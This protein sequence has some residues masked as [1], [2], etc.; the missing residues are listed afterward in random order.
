VTTPGMQQ[1]AV[2]AKSTLGTILNI[3][4]REVR[5]EIDRIAEAQIPITFNLVGSL[6]Q[7]YWMGEPSCPVTFTTIRGAQADVARVT[8]AVCDI[9]VSSLASNVIK[10]TTEQVSAQVRLLDV[11]GDEISSAL[12]ETH[13]AFV[14]ASVDVSPRRT[15]NVSLADAITGNAANGYE[16]KSTPQVIPSTV[17]VLGDYS[18][19][20]SLPSLSV[21]KINVNGAK[22]PIDTKVKILLPQDVRLLGSDEVEVRIDIG[23]KLG[24]KVLAKRPITV[25]GAAAGSKVTLTTNTVDVRVKAPLSQL[26]WIK[27]ATIQPYIDVTGLSKGKQMVPVLFKLPSGLSQDNVT[28]NL[29]EVEVNIE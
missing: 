22:V 28:A 18:L 21:G 10:Y 11:N 6:P 5:I 2:E 26:S 24:E 23:E 16:I 27:A 29:T 14:T 19:I 20:S 9:Q 3:S 8:R 13:T 17:D 1:L 12:F 15:V 7:G 25:T 4:P